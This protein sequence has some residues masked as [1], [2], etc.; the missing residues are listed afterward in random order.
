MAAGDI[1]DWPF[2]KQ[3]DEGHPVKSLQRLLRARGYDLEADG[4]FGPI[5]TNGPTCAVGSTVAS[6]ETNAVG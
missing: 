2:V 4:I 6:G 1:P 5:T 3:G